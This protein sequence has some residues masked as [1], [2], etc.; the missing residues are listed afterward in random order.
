MQ[1]LAVP[2][3]SSSPPKEQASGEPSR[4][5][6]PEVIAAHPGLLQA[7][8][9]LAHGLRAVFGTNP[10]LGRT[11]ASHQRWLL[12]QGA[13][14]LHLEYR[15]EDK[16]SGLTVGRLRDLITATSAASRNTVLNFMEEMRHY[17]YGRDVPPPDGTRSRRRR[18]EVTELAEE[19]MRRWFEVN[20]SVLDS[21]DGGT[22]HEICLSERGLF[23]DAQ[24]R[25]ARACLSDTRWLEPPPNVGL[26][27][28]TEGG[29]LVMDELVARCAAIEPDEDGRYSVGSINIRSMA[30]EYMMSHTYLQR[31]F[32]KAAEAGII[33]WSGQRRKADLWICKHFLL[34]YGAW[35]AVKLSH[36]DHAFHAAIAAAAPAA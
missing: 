12:A 24:P 8:A 3:S 5:L 1:N 28:W 15:P 36:L 33:G 34:E 27:Q 10:R 6:A 17:R 21:I 20:L 35:Q 23:A 16:N 7:L 26:F 31:L 29:A 2:T 30:D 9:A 32:R 18:V 22:R 4:P 13:V 19:A 11:L 25:M 14:A